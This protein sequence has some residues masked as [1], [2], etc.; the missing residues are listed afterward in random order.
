MQHAQRRTSRR[1]PQV[2]TTLAGAV[3][4]FG[5]TA[6]AAP[7]PARE[8]SDACTLQAAETR[9]VV[10]VRDAE[11]IALDNG[12]EVRLIGALAPRARD[13]GTD[14]TDWPPETAA[15]AALKELVLGKRAR[16]AYGGRRQDRYGRKL[17]HIFVKDDAGRETWVQGAML[18][19]GMARAYGLEGNF[20]CASE[21]IA[22]EAE[23]RRL[24]R[25]LWANGIYRAKSAA[26]AGSLLRFRGHF[27]HVT[28]RIAKV[29]VTKSA[30]YLNFGRDWRR[31]F[32]A[33]IG[34]E[35]KEVF[36]SLSATATKLEG[37]R[38]RV[39]GWIERRNG[40][41]IDIKDIS[42][43]ELTAPDDLIAPAH[44]KVPEA[45]SDD[46]GDGILT[47]KKRPAPKGKPG[48]V[49]L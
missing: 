41:M 40:P 26:R 29:A 24:Q 11:T 23:A 17:A 36:Q 10:A 38:V 3:L 7:A 39:R 15:V 8:T 9:T 33:R 4:A 34:K 46:D 47:K 31:D 49:D 12:D 44:N 32:T 42:Q 45:A 27:E 22:H 37:Q 1:L 18:E 43:L 21:L 14:E 16:L 35:S 13:T 48:A 19:Q 30:I 25:G 20:D 5:S 2:I 28:G 6:Q